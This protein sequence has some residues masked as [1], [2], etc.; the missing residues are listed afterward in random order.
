[1]LVG[2]IITLMKSIK[3]NATVKSFDFF[4]FFGSS[5][6]RKRDSILILSGKPRTNRVSCSNGWCS[7]YKSIIAIF[8]ICITVFFRQV[9]KKWDCSAI[10]THFHF[11][12]SKDKKLKIFTTYKSIAFFY[13]CG[14][15]IG[16]VKFRRWNIYK[17]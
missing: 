15:S 2:N 1:M 9:F 10:S 12:T 16:F 6:S 8:Y 17:N 4:S 11:L 14:G 5:I 13:S 7:L 3:K